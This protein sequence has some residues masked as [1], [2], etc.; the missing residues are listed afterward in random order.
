M[1]EILSQMLQMTTMK[2]EVSSSLPELVGRLGPWITQRSSAIYI[3][4]SPDFHAKLGQSL[5]MFKIFS[6]SYLSEFSA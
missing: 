1:V 5:M 3:E 6:G 4:L 2:I